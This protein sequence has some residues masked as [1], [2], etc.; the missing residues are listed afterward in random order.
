MCPDIET[1]CMCLKSRFS[2]IMSKQWPFFCTADSQADISCT[3]TAPLFFFPLL[4]HVK[5]KTRL[6]TFPS[7]W[8]AW[9]KTSKDASGFPG[10]FSPWNF[11]II[12][13]LVGQQNF[14]HSYQYFGFFP[15]SPFSPWNFP[16]L[17]LG[18]RQNFI[19]SDLFFRVFSL[20][21]LSWLIRRFEARRTVRLTKSTSGSRPVT[22]YSTFHVYIRRFLKPLNFVFRVQFLNSSQ[23][24]FVFQPFPLCKSLEA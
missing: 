22:L 2:S 13:C 18:C 17:Y 8:I 20:F 14:I 21:S 16:I 3:T 7:P 23:F 5:T 6:K 9:V 12:S 19:H 4:D 11:L 10:N 24:L 15:Y 1:P